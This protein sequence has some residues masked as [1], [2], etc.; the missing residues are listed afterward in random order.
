[1]KKK[2]L[3]LDQHRK[4]ASRLRHILEDIAHLGR[5]FQEPG[6]GEWLIPPAPEASYLMMRC[7]ANSLH[8][9]LETDYFLETEGPEHEK[10]YQLPDDSLAPHKHYEHP[11]RQPFIDRTPGHAPIGS[12]IETRDRRL[13]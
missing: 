1:M 7:A 11:A 12:Q 5:D 13:S 8:Y 2:E 3:T 10:I 6:T 9:Q 4:V